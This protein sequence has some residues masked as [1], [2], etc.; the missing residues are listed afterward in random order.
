[1]FVWCVVYVY[2]VWVCMCEDNVIGIAGSIMSMYTVSVMVLLVT[3]QY[4]VPVKDTHQATAVP[5]GWDR[6][7]V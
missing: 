2:I 1:M 5:K 4:F 7:T 6:L 3:T